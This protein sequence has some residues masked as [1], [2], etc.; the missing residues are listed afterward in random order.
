[1]ACGV[2]H[3]LV[4]QYGPGD[5]DAVMLSVRNDGT[6]HILGERVKP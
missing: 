2:R 6:M 4:F 3:I 5:V 1:M